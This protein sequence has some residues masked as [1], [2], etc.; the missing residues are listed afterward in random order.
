MP[1]KYNPLLSL[2]LDDYSLDTVAGDLRYLKL[3]QT[4]AQTITASPILNWLTA[5][6]VVFTD[7]NKKLTS[8]GIG[9]SSQFIK[10]DGSLDSTTYQEQLNG[11]GF[12]KASGTSISYDNSTYW[13]GSGS[14]ADTYVTYWSGAS[15]ITGNVKFRF[16]GTS[17]LIG[18][19]D[20]WLGDQTCTLRMAGSLAGLSAYSTNGQF[21]NRIS[22]LCMADFY[23]VDESARVR[24]CLANGAKA[25]QS[26][27]FY[28]YGDDGGEEAENLEVKWELGSDY[29]MDGTQTYFL[30]DSK[31]VRLSW[32]IDASNNFTAYGD[33]IGNTLTES[34]VVFT[35]ASKHLTSTGIGASTDFIKGDG[36]LDSSTYLTAES[37]TL[38]TVCGRGASYVAGN[39][40][41]LGIT[42]GANTL[43]TTEWAFL[44]GQDQAVKTTSDVTHDDL[45]LTGVLKLPTTTSTV[46]QIQIN[47]TRVFHTYGTSNTFVGSGAGNFTLTG[48]NNVTLGLN[49]LANLTS[50]SQNV[51]LGASTG[52]NISSGSWNMLIGQS[53]GNQITTQHANTAVGVNTLLSATSGNNT[54]IGY[55]SGRSMTSGSGA[56]T[57]IGFQA[58]FNASQLATATNSMALG[59]GAFTT[60]SNQIVFGNSSVTQI[61]AG[62]ADS[63]ALTFGAGQDASITFDG[64]S[65]N[66]IANAVSSTDALEF[67]AG[68]YKFQVPTDTDIVITF[69][70]TTSSGILTWDEDD[71]AFIFDSNS[72]TRCLILRAAD[73]L[74]DYAHIFVD[75][76]G[77]LRF[78]ASGGS[79]V[80]TSGVGMAYAEGFQPYSNY[81]S[82]D[83][84]GGATEDV[85]VGLEGGGSTTLHFK[86]GLYVGRD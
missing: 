44:D 83:G 56:N 38:D 4:T 78:S 29:Y 74:N 81:Y 3:D 53:S 69:G 12:V 17:I 82:V 75:A 23:A 64:N 76:A 71:S 28:F 13:A 1:L 52:T 63:C 79:V 42:I 40:T 57:F 7:A 59:N 14:G 35:D 6:K 47:A 2:G 73:G 80:L 41:L 55:N 62:V 22:Q 30:H 26:C 27:A 11:T 68:S 19:A 34:K 54:A 86:N 45:T 15:T 46:G 61:L 50:G 25:Q 65:L 9:T 60:A 24:L 36:S 43:T 20:P 49:N 77:I 18:D 8:T 48:T 84:T 10:G 5:S 37:D 33:I 58:G 16:D 39:V 72:D 66:I 67:T 85:A 32:L 70:G 31:N 21:Q 51:T